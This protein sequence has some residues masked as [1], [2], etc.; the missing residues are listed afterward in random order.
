MFDTASILHLLLFQIFQAKTDRS[1]V[2][3]NQINLTFNA[4]NGIFCADK[5]ERIVEGLSLKNMIFD[6]RKGVEGNVHPFLIP[7][8][9][10]NLTLTNQMQA[11]HCFNFFIDRQVK[12]V[13]L[14]PLQGIQ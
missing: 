8:T 6:I 4:F 5:T 1:N 14:T 9:E 11:F 2:F 3:F 13:I 12:E 7:L 10:G